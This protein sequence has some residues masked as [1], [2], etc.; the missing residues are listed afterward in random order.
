MNFESTSTSRLSFDIVRLYVGGEK[1]CCNDRCRWMENNVSY[2]KEQESITSKGFSQ[3]RISSIGS[4][5]CTQSNR[6]TQGSH[7]KS[8]GTIKCGSSHHGC[9]RRRKRVNSCVLLQVKLTINNFPRPT[10]IDI[11]NQEQIG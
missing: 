8:R 6:S 1:G 9:Q 11:K 4:S 3:Y 5:H 2:L 10:K 7:S